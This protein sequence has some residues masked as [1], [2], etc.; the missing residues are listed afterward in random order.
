MRRC[1]VVFAARG[2]T[3]SYMERRNLQRALR[4][5]IADDDRDTVEALALLLEAE[6]H[7]VHSVY[8]GKDVLPAARLFRPDAIVLDV[9]MPEMS[10]YAVAQAIRQS[11][12]D[13]RRPLLVAISG[14]WKQYADRQVGQQVGFDHYLEK[15]A[16]PAVLLGILDSLHRPS[17]G[18]SATR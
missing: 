5:L 16:N 1:R 17:A 3:L 7:V 8:T 15:P 2:S 11:F 12:T 10:G 4:V 9:A 13:L 14:V 18:A 6:G